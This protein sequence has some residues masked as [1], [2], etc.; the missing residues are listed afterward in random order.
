MKIYK[1]I[2]LFT[3]LIFSINGLMGQIT[4]TE[5]TI[6]E[7]TPHTSA[8]SYIYTARDGINLLPGFN[9]M[10][11][12]SKY[13]NGRIDENLVFDTEYGD[14]LTEADLVIDKNLPVGPMPGAFNVSSGGS[15][16]YSIPIATS[17]SASGIQPSISM[18]YNSHEGNGIM[19]VG[20]N[21]SGISAITRISKNYYYDGKKGG[22]NLTSTDRFALNGSRLLRNSSTDV[23]GANNVVYDTEIESFSTIVSK[24]TNSAMEG[25]EYFIV[26]KDNG[27][28]MEYGKEFNSRF[29][30]DNKNICWKISKISDHLGNYVTYHYNT[31]NGE[32][33]IS[34]IKYTGNTRESINPYN[35][36]TFFYSKRSDF[37]SLFVGGIT[38]NNNL[39]LRKIRTSSTEGKLKEYILK[40]T[41]QQYSLLTE[42]TAKTMTGDHLNSTKMIWS[43]NTY[44][45]RYTKAF[46]KVAN[47]KATA[48]NINNDGF[49]DVMVKP[50]SEAGQYEEYEEI[51]LYLNNKGNTSPTALCTV[52]V[53]NYLDAMSYDA[54][55]D[56]YDD[57]CIIQN[58]GAGYYEVKIKLNNGDGS[59]SDVPGS[60][61]DNHIKF[62]SEHKTKSVGDFNGDGKLELFLI[63]GYASETYQ[64]RIIE[65]INFAGTWQYSSKEVRI[66]GLWD[67]EEL[68]FSDFDGDGRTDIMKIYEESC[69]IQRINMCDYTSSFVHTTETIYDAGFPTK[70]HYVLTGDFN[71]DGKTDLLTY[72]DSKWQINCFKGA[73]MGFTGKIDAP[74]TS[75]VNPETD[76]NN[77]NYIV[78]DFG[79]DGKSDILEFYNSGSSE[80]LRVVNIYHSTGNS[81]IKKYSSFSTESNQGDF[82]KI[83]ENECLGDFSGDGITDIL[84]DN[85]RD[86]G[87]LEHRY[88]FK[89]SLIT[90]IFNGLYTTEVSYLPLS[91]SYVYTKE[92]TSNFPVFDIQS[93]MD[94]VRSVKKPDG[95]GRYSETLYHY[96]GGKIHRKGKG[97]L[98]FTTIESSN[99]TTDRK[100]TTTNLLGAYYSIAK[101]ITKIE[102]LSTKK[103]LGETTIN[104]TTWSYASPGDPIIRRQYVDDKT[105]FNNLS[106]ITTNYDYKYYSNGKL[107]KETVDYSDVN[108]GST[109]TTYTYIDKFANGRA[110]K[111]IETQNTVN[112]IGNE[113]YT[114]AISFVYGTNGL[115][116]SITI[117]GVTT[118][119]LYDN[120]G[121]ITNRSIVGTKHSTSYTY[122][123]KG[124]FVLSQM[125]NNNGLHK[126][127]CTYDGR[128]GNMLSSTTSNGLKTSYVYDSFG[129]L[130]QTV[131]PQGHTVS[132]DLFWTEDNSNNAYYYSHVS[133]P[134]RPD[135]W[136]Y[137][138]IYGRVVKTKTEGHGNS[139]I[140]TT[141]AYKANGKVLKEL[142]PHFVGEIADEIT[143]SYYKDDRI[144]S[145][146]DNLGTTSYK[147]EN[148]ATTIIAPNGTSTK[149]SDGAGRLVS[150]TDPGGTINYK[151]HPSNQIDEIQYSN[152]KTITIG[153]DANG[154]QDW[155]NDPDIGYTDYR[156]NK[157]GELEFMKDPNNN[158]IE[159]NYDDYGKLNFE[160]ITP[161]DGGT[162]QIDYDYYTSGSAINQ[163][164]SV[165]D[166]STHIYQHFTYDD[167]GQ[168]KTFKEDIP[169]ESSLITTYG[170]DNYGNNNYISYDV[171]CNGSIDFE[172]GQSFDKGILNEI[173]NGEYRIWYLNTLNAMGQVEEYTL[174][175]ELVNQSYNAKNQLK[176]IDYQGIAGNHLTYEYDDITGNMISR[177][178]TYSNIT[179][180]FEYDNLNRLTNIRQNGNYVHNTSYDLSGNI[181][182][183]TNA[184][185]YKYN[186]IRTGAIEQISTEPFSPDYNPDVVK[187]SLELDYTLIIP[188]QIFNDQ[189]NITYNWFHKTS[190]IEE[191][192]HNYEFTYGPDRQRKKMVHISDETTISTYYH[193]AYEKS[194]DHR[195]R[196]T[197]HKFYISSLSGICAIYSKEPQENTLY[198]V[199]KDHL[200]SVVALRNESTGN[201]E[202][203]YSYDAWGRR[204]DPSSFEYITSFRPHMFITNRGYTGH[205]HLD[206]AGLINMNGRTYDPIVGRMLSPDNY[207]QA[208][209]FTQSLNRYSYCWNNP[210]SYTD[211][212][213]EFLRTMAIGFY[214]GAMSLTQALYGEEITLLDN[215]K[216]S[217]Q[218]TD[219]L[220]EAGRETIYEN[221]N[222]SISAGVDIFSYGVS[223]NIDY[224][225]NDFTISGSGGYGLIGGWNANINISYH[226]EEG[227]INIG[228]GMGDNYKAWGAGITYKGYGA[229]YH[230][231]YYGDA[232]SPDGGG[233][234][235]AQTV[236]GV[237]IYLNNWSVKIENDFLAFK[238]EDRG[239]SNG[240]EI[241]Y[242]NLTIGTHLFNNDP[243]N[244]T[245]NKGFD[246]SE[247]YYHNHKRA[248]Y[249]KWNNGQTYSS[250]LYIGIRYG[251]TMERH[252]VNHH[253]FQH[254]T[255]NWGA[256]ESGFLRIMPFGHQNYYLDYDNFN[257][258]AYLYS[259]WNN[260][261]SIWGR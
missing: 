143:Y 52:E 167:F 104:M 251:N 24:E 98:G 6:E 174:G 64:G 171:D 1:N 257:Y 228:G 17:P 71:G 86:F 241:S 153:Y 161:G 191:G 130:L 178:D 236:G 139:I 19:G 151:Y 43:N 211:P 88:G 25:P 132:Q 126:T 13:L 137:Y 114:N 221:D 68:I 209:E 110:I 9:Y 109:E 170:Y 207:I 81:F 193:G 65:I 232:P 97:F 166:N 129:R 158:E 103:L 44:S 196:E 48:T 186:R 245:P 106:Q 60:F 82:D 58:K 260:P 136:Q 7:S 220:Y 69:E 159:Y 50:Y 55:G 189:Q 192:R 90:G 127:Q 111:L 261:Y 118:N 116:S 222:L 63:K 204:R 47:K 76:K 113:T 2:L 38:V 227:N 54:N 152:G 181:N 157:F 208:P 35:S 123:S 39:L 154:Y 92:N 230:Q 183:K 78:S 165:T 200:G 115:P 188:T 10:P 179:E 79:G 147:Y 102:V 206:E 225:K 94:V 51:K 219:E 231:T 119:Y 61:V 150:V 73:N 16:S 172:I 133:T 30:K 195:S 246:L 253:I 243:K 40:Y 124:R 247:E 75:T 125:V 21:I 31:I 29:T 163:L 117:Q 242:K 83:G 184:G 57:L 224:T 91:S 100:I 169:G 249:G 229:G 176:Q 248:K 175:N 41:E 239:R 12:T 187:G 14:V 223:A 36:I 240:I 205:E 215:I 96:A 201:I 89:S 128:T 256:H 121:N 93:G 197:F 146:T 210:L 145:I 53:R 5:T 255:Q 177:H 250:P 101:T 198:Y 156:Y 155:L 120:F 160:R 37:N 105:V 85:S 46:S 42:I 20:W 59:Y 235:Q 233:N 28:V 87:V 168:I 11:S 74:I 140:E 72:K 131:L 15:A 217:F 194:Y 22:I 8:K 185:Y 122:D 107:E 182:S 3:G 213:G 34:E 218:I 135:V 258:G 70:N 67:S 199:H 95:I 202:Q 138:D 45:G 4:K 149:I 164:K 180:S 162:I 148:L 80:I 23:Y 237:T 27:I 18:V 141:K 259:G 142:L 212:S 252:G 190:T 226:P 84:I 134:G 173:R 66:Q 238:G 234:S 216:L 144:Q 203:R 62:S 99:S 214:A 33:V 112:K 254:A 244:E 108:A 56:G 77:N 49:M 26:T 32:H